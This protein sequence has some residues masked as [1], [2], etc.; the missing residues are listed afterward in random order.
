MLFQWDPKKS[1][2]NYKKHKITFEEAKEVFAD[3]LSL[4]IPDSVHST[5]ED[6]WVT[7]GQ[8]KEKHV[9]LLVI[10]TYR[11]KENEEVIRII[12]ARKATKKEK[13]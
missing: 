6:R 1:E 12:S 11:S 3:P 13:R 4:T 9:L 10:H 8:T 5:N 7:L 2:A